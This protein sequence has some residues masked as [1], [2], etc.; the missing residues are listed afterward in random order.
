MKNLIV[1]LLIII[2]GMLACNKTPDKIPVTTKSETALKLYNEGIEAGKDIYLVKFRKLIDSAIKEDPDF[3]MAHYRIAMRYLYLR[4][5]TKFKEFATKAVDCK[6][7][8]SKGEVLIKEAFQKLIE[9][10]KADVTDYGQKLIDMY[11]QDEWSYFNQFIF[12]HV[13]RDTLGRINSMK[14]AIE[15]A[16]DKAPWYNTLGYAYLVASKLEDA[17][18]AFDKYIELRPNIP[19]SYDSK[20]DY[21]MRIKDYENAYKSFMKAHEIDTLWGLRKALIAKKILD[22][23]AV[24]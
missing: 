7:K 23:L 12:Q 3:F 17:E 1:S 5:E 9:N 8:L 16:E 19:N 18:A 21:F 11:P 13:I 10:Q 24:K 4:N 15:V 6:A 22:S 20:G 14:S 2:A